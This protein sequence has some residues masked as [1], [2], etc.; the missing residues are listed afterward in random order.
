MPVS[1]DDN[2]KTG[3]ILIDIQHQ[4]LFDTINKFD[5][6][7]NNKQDFW[8]VLVSLQKYV[9]E[10]FST[11][12]WF[13][14]DSNYPDYESHKVCHDKFIQDYEKLLDQIIQSRD[15]M[16][17]ADPMIIF[18]ENW[19][20]SHYTNEDVKMAAHLKEHFKNNL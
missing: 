17:L 18:V 3:V 14:K 11:E 7:K 10:H 2:L 19:I 1:W 5:E 15:I 20:T 16:H 8:E 9:T 13:M 6:A 4:L 12:E